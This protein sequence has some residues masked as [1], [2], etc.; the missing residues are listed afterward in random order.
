MKSAELSNHIVAATL[1]GFWRSSQIELTRPFV[2][3]FFADVPQVWQTHSSEMAHTITELFFPANVI[4]AAT[5]AAVDAAI[6]AAPDSGASGL[7]RLL[8][9][10]RD[11]LLRAERARAVDIAAS[12]T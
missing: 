10:G 6:A 5:L 2:E 9:E 1:Q 7:R 4:E 12:S 11:G 3:R 8:A